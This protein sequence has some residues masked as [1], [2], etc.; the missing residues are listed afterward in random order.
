MMLS[1]SALFIG[2]KRMIDLG[3]F[4]SP[5]QLKVENFIGNQAFSNQIGFETAVIIYQFTSH[6]NEIQ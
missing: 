6:E 5:K 3:F 1:L 2:K 4:K